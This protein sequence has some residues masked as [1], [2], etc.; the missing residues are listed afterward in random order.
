[1]AFLKLS[2]G[3]ED[4]RSLRLIIG[5]AAVGVV[6][7]AASL[8]ATFPTIEIPLQFLGLLP[9]V[10]TILVLAGVV[11]RA[12]PPAAIGKPYEKQ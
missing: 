12:I 11:G 1:M 5:T 2:R 4:K 8:L 7:I 10:V 9:Y 3:P 6:L